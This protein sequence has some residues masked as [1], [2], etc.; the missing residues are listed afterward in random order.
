MRRVFLSSTDR[1][2]PNGSGS[3]LRGEWDLNDSRLSVQPNEEL[4][5]GV[6][7]FCLP[8]SVA[9]TPATTQR[10][11]QPTD[12]CAL[13]SFSH[14][15][16]G[17]GTDCKLYFNDIIAAAPPSNTERMP[18]TTLTTIDNVINAL[19]NVLGAS[20]R[21]IKFLGLERVGT[22]RLVLEAGG[23][24]G[25]GVKLLGGTLSSP[26][27]VHALGLEGDVTLITNSIMTPLDYN[28]AVLMPRVMVTSPELQTNSFSTNIECSSALCSIP[29]V[30]QQASVPKFLDTVSSDDSGRSVLLRSLSWNYTP[31]ISRGSMKALAS[32]NLS[33]VS[34]EIR[35]P[36]G[37]IV[38]GGGGAP[39]SCTLDFAV[40]RNE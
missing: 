39:F 38:Y 21:I 36:L 15:P 37:Q 31:H 18:L 23:A 14:G 12:E 28:M 30:L 10:L 20:A 3:A 35:N 24:V 22:Y 4:L 17:D 5:V 34:L 19:N 25:Y 11:T 6:S 26:Q 33:S 32:R 1:L 13:L 9:V 2:N 7:Q 8:A 29:L 27:I 16:G 40:R